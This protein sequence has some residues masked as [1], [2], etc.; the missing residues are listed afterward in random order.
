MRVAALPKK[1]QS[2]HTPSP[3]EDTER[4]VV[5]ARRRGT[6][7]N[8]CVLFYSRPNRRRQLTY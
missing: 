3:C 6:V 7:T 5:F 4:A 1:P 8:K 2:P